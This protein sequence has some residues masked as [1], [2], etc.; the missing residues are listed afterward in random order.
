MTTMLRFAAFKVPQEYYNDNNSFARSST[1]T[2]SA[3][4]T[5]A[6]RRAKTYTSAASS[7]ARAA[8]GWTN[9]IAGTAGTRANYNNVWS[10]TCECC[11]SWH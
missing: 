6:S 2:A 3:I 4:T 11:R 8:S 7:S 1:S 5:C 9:S 10:R